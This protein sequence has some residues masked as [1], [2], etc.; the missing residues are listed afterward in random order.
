VGHDNRKTGIMEYWNIGKRLVK[1]KICQRNAAILD[2]PK[3]YWNN[4][5]FEKW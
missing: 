4:G 2:L 3:E 1:F 5:T